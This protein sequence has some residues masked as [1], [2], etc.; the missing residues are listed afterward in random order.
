MNE[1]TPKLSHTSSLYGLG[2]TTSS[3]TKSVILNLLPMYM[4]H[5]ALCFLTDLLTTL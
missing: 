5:G 4:L 1:I 3:Q 2:C